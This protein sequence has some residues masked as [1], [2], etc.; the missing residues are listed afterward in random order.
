MK[1]I[2]TLALI[3]TLSVKETKAWIST[4]L[5]RQMDGT[6]TAVGQEESSDDDHQ[7]HMM[8]QLRRVEEKLPNFHGYTPD[9][10]G[11]EGNNHLGGE[12]RDPYERVVPE[13]F[14]GD[15]ADTFTAKMIKDYAIEGQD[16]DS[17]KPN[18]K[19]YITKDACKRASYEVLATHLGL[20][21]AAADAHLKQYFDDVW[22]HMDVNHTGALEA[23]EINKFMRTLA[24]PIKEH[25]TLE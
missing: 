20:R 8:L 23:I 3:G 17:G 4:N 19:F 2:V 10:S 5:Q 11:F 9:Y 1:Y 24:K 22:D 25:I 6:F 15:T 7:P 16:K 18:G 14:T 21:G 13:M 12:W